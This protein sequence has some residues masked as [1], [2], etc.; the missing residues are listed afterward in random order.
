V[1][2]GAKYPAFQGLYYGRELEVTV[3]RFAVPAGRPPVIRNFPRKSC[4]VSIKSTHRNADAV[5]SWRNDT[6]VAGLPANLVPVTGDFRMSRNGVPNLLG[7]VRQ[8]KGPLRRHTLLISY[9]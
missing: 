5:T 4:K 7:D 9:S 1:L 2:M 8:I 6:D 3:A